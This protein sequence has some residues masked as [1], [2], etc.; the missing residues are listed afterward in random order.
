MSEWTMMTGQDNWKTAYPL[1]I[2][3]MIVIGV[4]NLILIKRLEKR[5]PPEV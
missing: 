5:K 4:I 3:A 2:V 1:F